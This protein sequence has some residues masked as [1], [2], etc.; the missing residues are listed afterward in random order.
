MPKK[1]TTADYE[2]IL[3]LLSQHHEG[4]GIKALAKALPPTLSHRTLQRRLT[5]LL[6]QRKISSKGKGPARCYAPLSINIDT[7]VKT[8]G[9]QRH[10]LDAYT[11]KKQ[12]ICLKLYGRIC[13]RLEVYRKRNSQEAP[14]PKKFSMRYSSISLGIPVD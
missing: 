14:M 2:T 12:P 3:H 4:I 11:P 7:S 6:K 8:T 9:Y 13:T 5:D 1:I 10:F